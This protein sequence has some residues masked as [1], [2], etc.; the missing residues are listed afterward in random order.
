MMV[1]MKLNGAERW[2]T[3]PPATR[4]LCLSS[5]AVDSRRLCALALMRASLAP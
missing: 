1:G 4:T 2:K 5:D 3:E